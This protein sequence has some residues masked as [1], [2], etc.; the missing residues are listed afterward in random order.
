[1]RLL[2]PILFFSFFALSAAAQKKAAGGP[3]FIEGIELERE[4]QVI[5]EK[6]PETAVKKVNSFPVSFAGTSIE[7]C[8]KLQ[9][10]YALMTN[11]DVESINN[12]NLYTFIDDWYNT[13]YRYGGTTKKGVDCSAFVGALT[14]SV[15]G[16]KLPR[17]AR[18]QYKWTDRLEKDELVEG[19]LVFFN[20]TGGVSHVGIYLG[21]DYFIHSSS[22][23]GVVIDNLQENYYKKRFLGGGRNPQNKEAVTAAYK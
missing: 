23:R 6:A 7:H 19:D 21:N 13:P 5:V 10:K 18:D 17:T 15:Y 8:S 22:S 14:N 12:V 20:T 4:Q 2:I 11:R 3:R 16:V 1:M 9:F